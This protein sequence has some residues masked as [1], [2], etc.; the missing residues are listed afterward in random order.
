MIDFYKKNISCKYTVILCVVISFAYFI[1]LY[2]LLHSLEFGDEYETII[3]ARM[4]ANNIPLYTGVFNHHGPLTFFS[5]F[6]IEL[7]GEFDVWVH[8]IPIAVLQL[9]LIYC[10]LNTCIID[11]YIYKLVYAFICINVIVVILP[12]HFRFGNMY[13]YQNICGLLAAVS[14]IK[15]VIPS[16][17]KPNFISARNIIIYNFII[18]SL[19]FLAITYGP[20]A[21]CMWL[22]ALRKKYFKFSLYGALIGVIFNVCFLLYIGSIKGY[23]A[24]HIFLNLK[25]LPEFIGQQSFV[26][27]VINAVKY[28]F[29]DK[30]WSIFLIY[31]LF[32][33]FKNEIGIIKWR[34]VLLFIM[35]LC[36]VLRPGNFHSLPY[37]YVIISLSVMYFYNNKLFNKLLNIKFLKCLTIIIFLCITIFSY[38]YNSTKLFDYVTPTETEFSKIVQAITDKDDKIICWSFDLQDYLF[39]HRLP[40]SGYI[41]YL[42]WQ[43]KYNLNPQ[44]GVIIDPISDIERNKP[45]IIRIDKWKVWDRFTWESYAS[46]I[47]ELIKNKYYRMRDDA[48]Y[49]IRNDVDITEFSEEILITNNEWDKGVSRFENCFIYLNSIRAHDKF[50]IGKKIILKN[51]EIREIVRIKDVGMYMWIYFSG[52]KMNQENL[53]MPLELKVIE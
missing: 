7:F 45:K 31:P 20:A 8:R 36:F 41:F 42:P 51:G 43:Y 32:N 35:I 2:K 13:L 34:S 24:Y 12:S 3:T 16:I 52:E 47:D 48:P 26:D 25:V 40:A 53:T 37:Y 50:A 11:N 4:L 28:I 5:G 33:T 21:L 6:I 49:Y 14:M 29:Q 46:D 39:S 38:K 10:I 23:L 17:I 30:V 22:L 1:Q 19:P 15:Y 44:Y 9:Y 18:S 27:M